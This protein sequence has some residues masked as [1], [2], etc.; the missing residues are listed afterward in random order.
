MIFVSSIFVYGVSVTRVQ[1]IVVL[2]LPL[3][4][5]WR[6]SAVSK[7]AWTQGRRVVFCVVLYRNCTVADM[8]TTQIFFDSNQL[9]LRKF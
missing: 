2:W 6:R 3:P 4:K 8:G 1:R 9:S 5:R 7:P